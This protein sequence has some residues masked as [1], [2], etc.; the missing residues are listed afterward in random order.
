MSHG[1]GARQR[2]ILAQIDRSPGKWVRLI[3][4]GRYTPAEEAST[5]RA[6]RTLEARGDIETS[7]RTI[8]GHVWLVARRATSRDIPHDLDVMLPPDDR[9][10]LAANSGTWPDTASWQAHLD[11]LRRQMQQTLWDQCVASGLSMPMAQTAIIA[12][13]GGLPKPPGKP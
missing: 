8:A 11:D 7:H 9:A 10:A 13:G 4:P 3:P 1:Y 5:R 2:M 6:A 12:M